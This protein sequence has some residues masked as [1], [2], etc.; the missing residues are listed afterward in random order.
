MSVSRRRPW[1]SGHKVLLTV[2]PNFRSRILEVNFRFHLTSPHRSWW[3]FFAVE[4]VPN[5]SP[6]SPVGAGRR[7]L[8][9]RWRPRPSR[10]IIPARRGGTP[11]A[12]HPH[13]TGD[14]E[15]S[16]LRGRGCDGGVPSYGR[17][18]AGLRRVLW[19]VAAVY[20]HT[21]ARRRGGF[22]STEFFTQRCLE[23]FMYYTDNI[24]LGICWGEG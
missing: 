22:E 14:R 21:H 8:P 5:L 20:R 10:R 11:P 9:S 15:D 6:N 7:A 4:E 16:N 12:A 2:D 23:D 17:I 24:N 13:R 1:L 19:I 18:G 3:S